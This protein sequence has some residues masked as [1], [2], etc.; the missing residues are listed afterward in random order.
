MKK[1]I[2]KL[3][4]E[5]KTYNEIK[6]ILGCSKGLISYH[7]GDG[8]KQKTIMRNRKNRKTIKNKILK[9][10]DDFFRDNVHGFKRGKSKNRTTGRFHYSSAYKK[11]YENPVCY[12]SGRAIDFENT[13]SYH[14]DHIIP[15][16]KGGKNDLKNM[17]LSRKE[18][19]RAKSDLLVNEFIELCIDVCRHNGYDVIK[20]GKCG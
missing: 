9:K 18:A 5:G 14:L 4:S 15:V 13:R 2:I 12:L 6:K 3:R 20:K 19:N 11:I 10:I 7:C 1:E 17:G 16:S 8:Q